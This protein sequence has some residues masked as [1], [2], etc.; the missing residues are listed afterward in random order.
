MEDTSPSPDAIFNTLIAYQKSAALKGA[1]DL[2]LFTAIGEGA[3][4]V[5]G[6][7]ERCGGTERGVRSLCDYLVVAGFLTKEN[8]VYKLTADSTTFLDR[9]SPAYMGSVSAFLNAPQLSRAFDDVAVYLLD[10]DGDGF[11]D[12]LDDCDD[13]DASIYPGGPEVPGNG[14]DEDCDGED[15]EP[16]RK[17][18]VAP[19]D[20]ERVGSGCGCGGATGSGSW[21]LVLLPPLMV[22]RRSST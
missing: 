3:C 11:S 19:A 7:A 13:R 5:A 1:I 16:S 15:D 9:K 10:R 21:L 6:L 22:R 20:L 17:W 2:D 4:S 8:D 18:N 14:I 12:L